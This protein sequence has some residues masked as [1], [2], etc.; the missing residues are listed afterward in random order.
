[1]VLLAE[2]R[3]QVGGQRVNEFLP[4]GTVLLFQPAQIV[5]KTGVAGLAQAARQAA[6]NHGV[7][8]IVQVDT[9]TL[10]NEFLDARK[11]GISPCELTALFDWTGYRR[12]C[13]ARCSFR[14][15]GATH[16][17]SP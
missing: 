3:G 11:I 5:V 14:R 16:K 13:W 1:M 10:I 9:G 4:L 17:Q 6:V 12:R 2:K 15:R 7:F 8:T